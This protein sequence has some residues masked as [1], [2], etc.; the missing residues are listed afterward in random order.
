M[1]SVNG[2]GKPLSV[3]RQAVFTQHLAATS[4]EQTSTCL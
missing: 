2:N 1:W 4:K 3:T